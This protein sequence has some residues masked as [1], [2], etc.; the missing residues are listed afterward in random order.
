MAQDN[1]TTT[2]AD[3]NA[4]T[5]EQN[6]LRVATFN[7]ARGL[8]QG[9][10][11]RLLNQGDDPGLRKVAAIIQKVRPDLLLLN[12]FDQESGFA[13]QIF[14]Q[15]YLSQ[16]QFGQQAIEYPYSYSAPVNT[17]L[18]SGADLN[19]DGKVEGP[20][21]AQGFGRFHGQY[22]MLVLSRWPISKNQVRSWQHLLW[23]DAPGAQ[24]PLAENGEPWYSPAA[25]DVLRLS[26]K[27][28]WDVPVQ[29]G[30]QELHFLV[31]H[32]TP[33]VF[34]GPEDRNGRRNHD[35]IGLWASL[36]DP[37]VSMQIQDDRGQSG[38][39]AGD[40]F[41]IIAGDMNADPSDGDST[42]N[43]MDQLLSHSLIN[44]SFIP[45]SAGA[46]EASQQQGGK[47]SQHRGQAEHDT[48]DF[49][50]Q[51]GPGNLRV[52]YV[53]PSRNIQVKSGGVFWPKRG[54]PGADWVDVS[55][56]RMVWLDISLPA[57]Q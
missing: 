3:P 15:K 50:D 53:L 40:A 26:S 44:A 12:E 23:R 31:S 51:Q 55:D 32:P 42:N 30:Q 36:L 56:H 21:D 24:L 11:H 57:K 7:M 47:N 48:T 33:P 2:A 19:N 25:L 35:E 9:E 39:L 13:A 37:E 18:P 27:S 16:G 20:G 49:D 8:E 38:G 17:G 43:A 45:A 1:Q 52:D 22:A 5:A 29:V 14:Q 28:H 54:E 4:N 41:F 46:V 34:D 10:L 6:S